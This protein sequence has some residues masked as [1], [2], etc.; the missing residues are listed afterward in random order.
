EERHEESESIDAFMRKW[1]IDPDYSN[2]GAFKLPQS[3]KTDRTVYLL[4]RS[5]GKH[6]KN[7]GKTTGW[8]HRAHLKMQNVIMLGN[9]EYLEFSD[10]GFDIKVM[11]EQ[12]LLDVDQLIVCAGQES[13]NSLYHELHENHP[14]VHL[15]GGAKLAAE[16]DAK[17]AIKEAAELAA[18]L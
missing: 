1:G 10:K 17:R 3:Q 15:I 4:K 7:L 5:G 18:Q 8:I 2:P 6:G 12:Q 13:S 16:L 9:V 14:G 11:E